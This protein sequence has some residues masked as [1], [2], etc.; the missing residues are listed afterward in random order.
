MGENKEKVTDETVSK[1]NNSGENKKISR[2]LSKVFIISIA[3]NKVFLFLKDEIKE[4][5]I[6]AKKNS[7]NVFRGNLRAVIGVLI[8]T[9]L[10]DAVAGF[11]GNEMIDNYNKNQEIRKIY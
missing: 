1:P 11:V 5:F 8:N 6:Y 2:K 7:S 10:A 3:L 9:I 4:G